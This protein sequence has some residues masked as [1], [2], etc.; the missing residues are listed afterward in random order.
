MCPN[1]PVAR[2][3]HITHE[4]IKMPALRPRASRN[5]E[6]EVQE[7]LKSVAAVIASLES[8]PETSERIS[9]REFRELVRE[10]A[11]SQD[12]AWLP[13]RNASLRRGLR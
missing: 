11:E 2:L 12:E 5:N 1:D 9:H 4:V 3:S 10:E 8:R 7:Q 13:I 6:P